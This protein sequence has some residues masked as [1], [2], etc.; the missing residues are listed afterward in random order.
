ME[1]WRSGPSGAKV[2]KSGCVENSSGSSLRLSAG[3]FSRAATVS[4]LCGR[5]RSS[6]SICSGWP[7]RRAPRRRASV[8][9]PTPSGPEKSRVCA[10]R[11]LAIIRSSAS[12]TCGLPQK[13]SNICADDAPNLALDGVGIGAPVDHLD[14]LRLARGQRVVG[15]VNLAVEFEG[16]IVHA[17]FAVRLRQIAGAGARQ[18]GFGVDVHQ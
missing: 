16:L 11:W 8:A 5:L 13:L 15:L 18:T 2:T 3:H 7:N 1:I 10:R 9:L 12:V 14:A 17:G 4:R 6:S